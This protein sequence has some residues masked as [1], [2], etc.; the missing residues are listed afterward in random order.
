MQAT[1][2]PGRSSPVSLNS[3]SYRLKNG[4]IFELFTAI[5]ALQ[6]EVATKAAD[7]P[8][9]QCPSSSDFLSNLE[10]Q[11]MVLL[12]GV[13]LLG[14]LVRYNYFSGLFYSTTGNPDERRAL[15]AGIHE[16]TLAGGMVIDTMAGGLLGSVGGL[17]MPYVVAAGVMLALTVVHI[18]S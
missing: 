12:A 11:V 14:Q 9:L 10:L 1:H 3:I 4:P 5:L 16:A 15:A 8:Q 18:V 6:N 13:T 17:R 7:F 2:A